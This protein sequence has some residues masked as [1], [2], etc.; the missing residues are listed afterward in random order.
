I[1][2]NL[3]TN[4][5][6]DVAMAFEPGERNVLRRPPRRRDAGLMS[7]LLWERGLVAAV[8]MAA[9]TLYLFSWTLDN[10]GSL[11][12]AQAAALTTMVL[13][14]NFQ[15]GNARS[16]FDSVF[17]RSPLSN[18]FLFLAAASALLV[19]ISALHLG[20]TQFLLQ[21]EPIEAGVWVRILL[22]SCRL[23][24]CTSS[25]A[26]ER[27]EHTATRTSPNRRPSRL[28]EEVCTS[29]FSSP[30]TARR[31]PSRCFRTCACWPRP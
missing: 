5:L 16:E 17:R 12:Q 7:A 28:E 1:W 2:L 23:W 8:V 24:S 13:F 31:S 18:R 26:G 27:G 30:S 11:G 15:V 9:G 25:S 22:V 10:T 21:V 19:H 14:Q 3:V 4:G 20:P 6:Q 29:V